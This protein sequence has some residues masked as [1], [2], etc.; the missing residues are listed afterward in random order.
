MNLFGFGTENN[1]LVVNKE[2]WDTLQGTI[3]HPIFKRTF[4]DKFP[5]P[6]G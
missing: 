4:E 5:F 2:K 6:V 3:T 1:P